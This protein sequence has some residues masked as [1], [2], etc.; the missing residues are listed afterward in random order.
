MDLVSCYFAFV[1]IHVECSI[2]KKERS[3]ANEILVLCSVSTSLPLHLAVCLCYFFC[4][5]NVQTALLDHRSS[6][7]FGLTKAWLK[8]SS[9]TG[10]TKLST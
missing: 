10:D 3:L 4:L 1:K 8:L 6:S 9:K 5:I 2:R 7:C